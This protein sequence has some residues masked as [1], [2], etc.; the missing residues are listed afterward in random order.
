MPQRGLGFRSF[1]IEKLTCSTAG[2]INAP[3]P[4]WGAIDAGQGRGAIE[5]IL[6]CLARKTKQ[7]RRCTE[8]RED[9]LKPLPPTRTQGKRI[10]RGRVSACH[11]IT[12]S[13][14]RSR[15]FPSSRKIA[16]LFLARYIRSILQN[17]AARNALVLTDACQEELQLQP[18]DTLSKPAVKS[19]LGTSPR[20]LSQ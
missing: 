1:P 5:R 16:K 8:T 2:S 7:L 4:R 18:W 10:C 15:S 13:R 14:R 20:L 12:S 11:S 19:P 6:R 9:M 3:F 17:A